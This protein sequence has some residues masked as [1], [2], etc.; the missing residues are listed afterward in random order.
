MGGD[1]E[2]GRKVSSQGGLPTPARAANPQEEGGQG[3][4]HPPPEMKVTSTF[5]KKR[6]PPIISSMRVRGYES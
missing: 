6:G 4:D 5:L 2:G 1:R 3:A